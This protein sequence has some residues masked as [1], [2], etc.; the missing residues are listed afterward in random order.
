MAG[1]AR[2][3]DDD[4]LITAINVTPLVD[5]TLV[6]LV[7]LMVTAT[8]VAARNIPIEVP[9]AQAAGQTDQQPTTLAITVDAGG[10]LMLDARP[11][12]LTQIGEAARAARAADPETRA[13]I[14]SSPLVPHAR[15]VS[16]IDTLR[17][18]NV[19]RFAFATPAAGAAATAASGTPAATGTPA[20]AAAP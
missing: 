1:G 12:T 5:V 8:A 11:T 17:A 15:V 19:L 6:L 2:D 3:G 9:N 16:L 10:N 14:A 4:G 13:I 7:V 18:A 20:P